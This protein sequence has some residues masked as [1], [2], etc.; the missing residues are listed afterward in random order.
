M[1]TAPE[2]PPSTLL[3]KTPVR[4]TTTLQRKTQQEINKIINL[5]MRGLL[6]FT[7]LAIKRSSELQTL[8]CYNLENTISNHD[9]GTI[10]VLTYY[11]THTAMNEVMLAQAFSLKVS[12]FYR[13]AL[14][15]P[16]IETSFLKPPT[17]SKFYHS[18]YGS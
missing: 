9:T 15:Q 10:Q 7:L 16:F 3:A 8:T 4:Y 13:P 1:M 2:T 14:S 6:S 12:I 17:T 18:F 11:Y 5:F